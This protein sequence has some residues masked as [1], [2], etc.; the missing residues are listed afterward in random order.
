MN[1]LPT[2]MYVYP[3][4]TCWFPWNWGYRCLWATVPVLRIELSSSVRAESVPNH[5]VIAPDPAM[6]PWVALLFWYS[7]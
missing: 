5:R 4:H 6:S 2:Y 1:V 3:V 7:A